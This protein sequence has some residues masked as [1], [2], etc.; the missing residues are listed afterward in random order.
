MTTGLTTGPY[1][2]TAGVS[3]SLS[4]PY[5]YSTAAASVQLQ[6]ATGFL[7]TVQSSGAPYTIQPYTA[8][9]IPTIMGGQTL[10]VL[11]TAGTPNQVGSLT[12]V[13]LLEGQDPPIPDGSLT[14]GVANQRVALEASGNGVQT[15]TIPLQ[16]TDLSMTLYFTG[17]WSYL[18]YSVIGGDTGAAYAGGFLAPATSGGSQNVGPFAISGAVDTT[19]NLTISAP[20]ASSWSVTAI[21]SSL[22]ASFVQQAAGYPLDVVSYGGAQ[23]V[24]INLTSTSTTTLLAAPAAGTATRIHSVSIFGAVA[25]QTIRFGQGSNPFCTLA[26]GTYPMAFIAEGLLTTGAVTA[27]SSAVTSIFAYI[28]YDTVTIPYIN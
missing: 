27:T 22:P 14:S 5:R 9:T 25:G 24:G 16:A 28:F 12:A 23:S 4:D 8:S 17:T 11:P 21:V 7:L 19:V 1:T 15:F 2:L 18:S 3:L 13:W 26:I 6:N 20:S 10:V